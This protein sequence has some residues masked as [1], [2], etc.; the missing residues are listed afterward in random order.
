MP[1]WRRTSR[2]DDLSREGEGNRSEIAGSKFHL[3]EAGTIF[4]LL[5]YHTNALRFELRV[6]REVEAELRKVIYAEVES[7]VI[8][9]A[10]ARTREEMAEEA[11]EGETR[12]RDEVE[13]H[14]ALV[15]EACQRAAEEAEQR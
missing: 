14:I 15:T 13:A 2:G 7:R 9:E 6:N 11:L 12:R 1:R 10:E 5:M 4:S 3:E 8:I